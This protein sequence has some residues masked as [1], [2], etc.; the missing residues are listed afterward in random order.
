[1]MTDFSKVLVR[2]SSAHQIMTNIDSAKLTAGHL[3]F[4]KKIFRELRWRRREQIKSK[5]LTKGILQEEDAITLLTRVVGLGVIK[6]NEANIT[7]AFVSG[8]PDIFIGES[9]RKAEKGYDTKCSWSADTFPF[10]ED[11][12]DAVYEWQDHVYIALT[13]AKSWVTAFCLVNAPAQQIQSEKY[14]LNRR[15]GDVSETDPKYIQGCV[16]IERNMIYD[17]QQFRKDNPYY[18]LHTEI[19]DYDIPMK[20]RIIQYEVLRDDNKIDRLY[21]RVKLMRKELERLAGKTNLEFLLN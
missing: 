8:T 9:I 4:C 5:Y 19:W 20:E 1:M 14:Q 7:N 13:G 10:P 16:E 17:M 11:P 2:A 15:L 21:E 6:K 12:L 3:T 18:E